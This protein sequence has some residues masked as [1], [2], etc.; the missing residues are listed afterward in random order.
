MTSQTPPPQPSDTDDASTHISNSSQQTGREEQTGR[1]PD[2]M[3]PDSAPWVKSEPNVRNP[4]SN[5]P[6]LNGPHSNGDRSSTYSGD[7]PYLDDPRTDFSEFTRQSPPPPK[8]RRRKISWAKTFEYSQEDIKALRAALNDNNLF[9]LAFYF[10][11]YILRAQT[12]LFEQI[13]Q[14]QQLPRIIASM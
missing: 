14:Q 13:H 5:E 10:L 3:N 1:E 4:H 9:R 6:R 7:T 2:Y 8:P 12:A 11:D